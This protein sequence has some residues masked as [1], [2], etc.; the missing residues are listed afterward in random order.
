MKLYLFDRTY[1]IIHFDDLKVLENA[2]EIIDS[3]RV[4][5]SQNEVFVVQLAVLSDYDDVIKTITSA[6]NL[7]ISCINIDVVDKYAK[8]KK[9]C[10]QIKAGIMQPLFFT[11]QAEKIGKR[12]ETASITIETEKETRTFELVFNINDS[13]VQNNGYN[14]L[15]RLSRLKWLNSDIEQNDD[16]IKHRSL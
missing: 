14:D 1:K 16:I 9:Q 8:S 5:M 10:V 3:A 4:T 6:G 11:V 12:E 7:K 2:A 15:W 13:P